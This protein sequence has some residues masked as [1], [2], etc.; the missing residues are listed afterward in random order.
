MGLL[1]RTKEITTQGRKLP[2]CP[3]IDLVANV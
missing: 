1:K 2:P 3:T